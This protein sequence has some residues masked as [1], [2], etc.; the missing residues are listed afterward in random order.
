MKKLMLLSI[1]FLSPFLVFA[2]AF[3]SLP[4][5]KT[6]TLEAGIRLNGQTVRTPA[7]VPT[8]TEF[9]IEWKSSG[10]G[11]LGDWSEAVLPPSGTQLGTIISPRTFTVTCFARGAARTARIKV[12]PG[13]RDLAVSSFTVTPLKKTKA[14]GSYYAG[15]HTFKAVIK[16]NGKLPVTNPFRMQFELSTDGT[17]WVALSD[18]EV[19]VFASA[20]TRPLVYTW[21]SSASSDK[22]YLRACAD[23]TGKVSET[24]E[25]NNCSKVLGPY[26]FVAAPAAR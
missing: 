14:A 9:M 20:A 10:K 12:T 17:R 23:T 21:K 19:S 15:T 25:T 8:D 6:I 13:V 2:D 11:C 16:N 7:V 26:T 3:P 18:T 1:F 4:T 5:V 24:N 22:I